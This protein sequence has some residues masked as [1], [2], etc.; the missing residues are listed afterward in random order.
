MI[1]NVRAHSCFTPV[2]VK[3]HTVR[4]ILIISMYIEPNDSTHLA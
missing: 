4:V 1:Y 3:E 2:P